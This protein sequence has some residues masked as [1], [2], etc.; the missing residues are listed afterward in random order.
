MAAPSRRLKAMAPAVVR[1]GR[2]KLRPRRHRG[3]S[4]TGPSWTPR[5]RADPQDPPWSTSPAPPGEHTGSC[6]SGRCLT[7][8]HMDARAQLRD[9]APQGSTPSVRVKGSRSVVLLCMPRARRVD[10][11]CARRERTRPRRVARASRGQLRI[12]AIARV[13]GAGGCVERT[14][15]KANLSFYT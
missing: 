8:H 14:T 11:R 13:Y 6:V 15:Q 7:V 10:E 5:H 12:S 2:E 1:G 4:A 9:G 3:A